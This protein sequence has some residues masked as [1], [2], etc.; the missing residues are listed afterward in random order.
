MIVLH[1]F[2]ISPFC[3]KVR[4][5][6]QFKKLPYE[7][8]E[9]PTVHALTGQIRR[10][11]GTG[12]LPY[13]E[14]DGRMVAD[15]SEIARYLEERYPTP[16]ILPSDPAARARCHVLEDWADESLYFY[17]ML[18]RFMLPHNAKRWIPVLVRAD[19]AP[20]RAGAPMLVPRT[21]KKQLEAQGLGR[22]K[23]DDVLRDLDRHLD[24]V[25]GWLGEGKWLVGDALTLA[26]I[27]VYAQ[28]FC[29]GGSDEGSRA[30]GKR[31]RIGSWMKRVEAATAA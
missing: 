22:K 30:I 1:Q 15:S 29:V 20:V 26:D 27:S 5:I 13:L 11:N 19:A 16:P 28:L 18:L 4:R 17:E 31:Q 23:L 7:T 24:A 2:E 8:R 14:D 25:D 6:L 3:D 21:L 10:R 12:K 9:V